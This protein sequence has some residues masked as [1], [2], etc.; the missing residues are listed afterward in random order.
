L[1]FNSD[2]NPA[3]FVQAASLFLDTRLEPGKGQRPNWEYQPEA[4]PLHEVLLA[5]GGLDRGAGVHKRNTAFRLEQLS[6]DE[7]WGGLALLLMER[8]EVLPTGVVLNEGEL[9]YPMHHMFFGYL[10]VDA[11]A[12][13]HNRKAASV[14]VIEP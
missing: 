1:D 5:A 6:D 11:I 4:R 14:T 10:G 7:S 2:A 3:T 8:N 12:A 13:P 9:T